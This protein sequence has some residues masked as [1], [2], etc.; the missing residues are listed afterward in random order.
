MPNVNTPLPDFKVFF[1]RLLVPGE[2]LAAQGVIPLT[3]AQSSGTDTTATAPQPPVAQQIATAF[4]NY[5]PSQYRNLVIS[6]ATDFAGQ[7]AVNLATTQALV[8]TLTKQLKDARAQLAGITALTQSGATIS[9]VQSNNLAQDA[10]YYAGTTS[11]AEKYAKSQHSPTAPTPLSRDNSRFISTLGTLQSVTQSVGSGDPVVSGQVSNITFTLN[12]LISGSYPLPTTGAPTNVSLSANPFVEDEFRASL[13]SGLAGLLNTFG[14]STSQQQQINQ[15]E[16]EIGITQSNLADQQS[17]LLVL[18]KSSALTPFYDPILLDCLIGPYQMTASLNRLG[19]PGVGSV[20]FHL[21]LA[22]NGQVPNLFFGLQV[23]DVFSLTS[24]EAQTSAASG[25]SNGVPIPAQTLSILTPNMRETT[26]Q[27]F[28][29]MQIWAR[30]RYSTT[31]NFPGDYHPV[32]TGFVTKTN[33]SYGGSTIAVKVDGEDVGKMVR[34]ARIDAD[35]SLDQS[36]N[37]L[38]LGLSAYGNSLQAASANGQTG[39]QMVKSIISGQA[40]SYLGM[41]QASFITTGFYAGTGAQQTLVT[42]PAASSGTPPATNAPTAP[43][44][45]LNTSVVNLAWDF[46]KILVNVFDDLINNL[47]VY[48]L[49]LKTAFRTWQTDELTKWEVCTQIAETQE[50][51]LYADNLGVINYHPPFYYLNPFSPQYYIENIDI[52][53]ETHTTDESQVATVMELDTQPS[54]FANGSALNP[55]VQ[56][57]S[58]VSAAAT[59]MQR[60]GVRYMKKSAPFFSDT[61]IPQ[62]SAQKQGGDTTQTSSDSGRMQY[63]R[64]LLNRR[65]ARLKSANITINGTPEM[66]LCN[67]VAM[68]GDLGSVLQ[69]ASSNPFSQLAPSVATGVAPSVTLTALQQ[70]LVYYISAITHNYT[71]GKDFTTTLTLTHGRH[72]TDALPSGNVGYGTSGPQ[73]NSI[74]TSMLSFWGQSNATA[75]V[76][77]FYNVASAKLAFTANGTPLSPSTNS[78]FGFTAQPVKP[79]TLQAFETRLS[80]AVSSAIL[81]LRS[82]VCNALFSEN[83]PKKAAQAAK[84]EQNNIIN[85]IDKAVSDAVTKIEAIPSEIAKFFKNESGKGVKFFTAYTNKLQSALE[86][87]ALAIEDALNNPEVLAFQAE[88]GNSN[89]KIIKSQSFTPGTLVTATPGAS[90]YLSAL[91]S[92]G[93]NTSAITS[94]GFGIAAYIYVAQSPT[95]IADAQAK[96]AT[97]CI[98]NALTTL[99]IGGVARNFAQIVLT[100]TVGM[101]HTKGG[102]VPTLPPPPSLSQAISALSPTSKSS[103]STPAAATT[104]APQQAYYVLGLMIVGVTPSC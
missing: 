21:P 15:L 61:S 70:V 12:A 28:D 38:G 83:D 57:R 18:Q 46:Q 17:N 95:S 44:T 19:Q 37:A 93:V 34:L 90:V 75:N 55:I 68:V 82:S 47:P 67:T 71:Q 77:N 84:D 69:S 35:P 5:Q 8:A 96:S 100:S 3:P 25:A 86:Q 36:L 6:K 104:P 42:L 16:G 53:S 101:K 85:A 33:V 13:A 91:S 27:P 81:R 49:Q 97:Q 98:N 102:L 2:S 40:G 22:A 89:F 64:A 48:A 43:V 87:E 60:Y 59:V 45:T 11:D 73:T 26:I 20:T 92:A 31:A 103:P 78:Q 10:A 1:R 99:K 66:R 52:V 76:N 23:N 9:S 29:M 58:F 41:S 94:F 56:G 65:N 88:L 7:Q 24:L 30:R 63:A 51:E 54:F 80:T 79:S 39:G 14:I 74:Y 32:F 50:F 4:A 72:W 62:N